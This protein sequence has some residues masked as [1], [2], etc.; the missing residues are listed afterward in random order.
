MK[1][2]LFLFLFCA[3][4]CHA[5]EHFDHYDDLI[6]VAHLSHIEE[7]TRKYEISEEDRQQ[8]TFHIGSCKKIFYDRSIRDATSTQSST[9]KMLFLY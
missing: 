7:I 4:Y 9:Q 8:L 3:S 5:D 1:N 2:V 6:G